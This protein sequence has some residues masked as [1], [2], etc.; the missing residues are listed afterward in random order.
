VANQRAAVDQRIIPENGI[1][2]DD[3]PRVH[4]TKPSGE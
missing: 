1:R 4:V 3:R 2:S